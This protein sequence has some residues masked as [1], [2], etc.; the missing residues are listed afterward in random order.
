MADGVNWGEKS[1]LAARCAV[2]G[3][4]E[5]IHDQL[6]DVQ[7]QP[8]KTTHVRVYLIWNNPF[9]VLGVIAF[10]LQRIV[11]KYFDK[12]FDKFFILIITRKFNANRIYIH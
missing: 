3:A 5:Y 6:F 4:V 7:T 2:Y 11:S 8:L 10:Y 1:M 12:T 9:F